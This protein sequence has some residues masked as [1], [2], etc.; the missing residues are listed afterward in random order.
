MLESKLPAFLLFKILLYLRSFTHS[1]SPL[2]ILIFDMN[3]FDLAPLTHNRSSADSKHI[4]TYLP[5]LTIHFGTNQPI[6]T[7]LLVHTLTLHLPLGACN[8]SPLASKDSQTPNTC[9]KVL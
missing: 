7:C 8:N 6:F 3:Y 1:S 9:L 2:A 5:L 4:Y